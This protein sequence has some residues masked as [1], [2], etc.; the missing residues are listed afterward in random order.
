MSV[1]RYVFD[2]KAGSFAYMDSAKDGSRISFSADQ[3]LSGWQPGNA[4]LP[5]SALRPRLFVLH[6]DGSGYEVLDNDVVVAY[7]WRQVS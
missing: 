3:Q 2:L 6:Q 4:P 7:M 5:A 1:R